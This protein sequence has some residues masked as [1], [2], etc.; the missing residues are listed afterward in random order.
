MERNWRYQ[1]ETGSEYGP[2]T[3]EELERYAREGRVN[4]DGTVAGPDGNW[5]AANDAGLEFPDQAENALGQ[6]PPLS[7]EEAIAKAKAAAE[8]QTGDRSPHSRIA[9][10]LLGVLLPIGVICGLGIAGINNLVVGR[11]GPGIAQLTLSIIAIICFWIGM[12]VGV[13]LC[14]SFPLWII[15]LVW[16]IIEVCTNQLD[17]QGRTMV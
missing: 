10:I 17:G 16:S 3:R 6:N 9:Y 2:Y 14:I 11:T 1:D 15:V 13:T 7:S 5:I 8:V 12:I 4:P